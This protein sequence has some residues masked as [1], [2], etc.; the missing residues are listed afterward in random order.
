MIFPQA[1][2]F[3]CDSSAPQVGTWT[4]ARGVN[5]SRNFSE[6]YTEIVES[7]QN[8]TLV[9]TTIMVGWREIDVTLLENFDFQSQPYSMVRQTQ[10]RLTGNDA[11]EGFAIDLMAEIAQILSKSRFTR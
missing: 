8:K 1:T 5:M 7:L 10:E 11:F 4:E 3:H 2:L 9:I 6:T